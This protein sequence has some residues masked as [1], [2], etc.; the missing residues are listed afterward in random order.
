MPDTTTIQAR[1]RS[2]GGRTARSLFASGAIAVL[3]TLAAGRGEAW[4]IDGVLPT[5]IGLPEANVVLRPSAGAGPYSGLDSFGSPLT[6]LRMIYDTGASG[7]I[8]FEGPAQALA[9]PVAQ[10][11]GDDVVFTDVGVGGNTTFNVS[12]ALHMSLGNFTQDPPDP[13]TADDDYPRQTADLRLQLG[14]PGSA[15]LFLSDFTQL[16]IAGM[17]AMAGRVSVINPKLAEVSFAEL[18]PDDTIHTYVYDPAVPPESGPGILA[19]NLHVELFMKSFDRFTQTTPA[20]ATGP[21]LNANPF[22]GP[23]P[24]AAL[25]GVFPLPTTPPGI[26]VRRGGSQ[27]TGTFLLDTGSQI[28]S[29]SSAMALALGVRYWGPGDPGYDPENPATLVNDSDGSPIENQFTVG[30]SGVAGTTTI[31]GFNVDSLLVRTMEGDPLVDS[32]PNHLDFT[33]APVFVHDIELMDPVTLDTF[34]FDG[35]LGTNYLFGSGDLSALSG[36]D[37]PFRTGPFE[38]LVLDFAS[39]TPTLGLI[40]P[41]PVPLPLALHLVTAVLIGLAGVGTLRSRRR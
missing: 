34:T 18:T 13:Y 33:S 8:V 22:I 26:T 38:L 5:S 19:P 24:L 27:A 4:D 28:T 12:D 32:D 31:A 36:F 3:C 41:A 15:A 21:T 10:L 2:A 14:P 35:V 40:L 23:D 29:I 6:N 17:P 25:E 7:V 37:V 9:L 1:R 20:G 11:L 16:G 39:P 30:I